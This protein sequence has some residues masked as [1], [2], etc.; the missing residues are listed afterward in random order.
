MVITFQMEKLNSEG[1]SNSAGKIP[2]ARRKKEW[3]FKSGSLNPDLYFFNLSTIL[4]LK[5]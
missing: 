4:S 2:T 1:L 3:V 5:D